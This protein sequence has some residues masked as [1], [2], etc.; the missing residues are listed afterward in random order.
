MRYKLQIKAKKINKLH[1]NKEKKEETK[2]SQSISKNLELSNKM[3]II[4]KQYLY[5]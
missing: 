4:R 2:T 1:F 5:Q 3:A